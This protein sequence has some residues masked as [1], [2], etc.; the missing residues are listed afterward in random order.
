M[1]LQHKSRHGAKV[2]K[3]YDRARTPYQRV[4]EQGVMTGQQQE[5]LAD[6][7]QR[8]NPVRLLAQINH[9]LERLWT[10]AD[11]KTNHRGS[12]TIPS[13]ATYALR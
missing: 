11:T 6:Q 5:A 10:L 4:L 9:A 2:H 7:Y 3:V 1:Q 12:V 8:L 13:E